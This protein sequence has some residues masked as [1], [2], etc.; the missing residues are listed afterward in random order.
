MLTKKIFALLFHAKFLGLITQFHCYENINVLF[1][2]SMVFG[3]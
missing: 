2:I 1:S 3:L